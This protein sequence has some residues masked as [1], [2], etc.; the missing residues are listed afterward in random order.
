MEKFLVKFVLLFKP[1]V[2][3]L[4]LI[5]SL[6]TAKLLIDFLV[7]PIDHVAVVEH[8]KRLHCK[9]TII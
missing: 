7:W 1:M 6:N 8:S 3:Y 2:N 9:T 4:A 5:S